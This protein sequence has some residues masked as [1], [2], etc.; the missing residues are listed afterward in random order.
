VICDAEYALGLGGARFREL[1][2]GAS[3]PKRHSR[4]WPWGGQV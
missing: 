1:G 2:E 3:S 4:T